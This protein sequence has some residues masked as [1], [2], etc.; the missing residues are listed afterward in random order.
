[1]NDECVYD[2]FPEPALP[3]QFTSGPVIVGDRVA[4]G[5]GRVLHQLLLHVLEDAR[6]S[7]GPVEAAAEVDGGDDHAHGDDG[8]DAED[9]DQGKLG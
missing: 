4:G 5:L 2:P 9:Q 3:H 1:M 7:V 6:G 8:R